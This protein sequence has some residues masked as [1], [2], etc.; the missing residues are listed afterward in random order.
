M[1]ITLEL[2]EQWLD[3][4]MANA[5]NDALTLGLG[6]GLGA[7][8]IHT[9]SS[10]PRSLNLTIA[11]TLTEEVL[12]RGQTGQPSCARCHFHIQFVNNQCFYGPSALTLTTPAWLMT[13]AADS[14][15]FITDIYLQST[16]DITLKAA[17]SA[18][19]TT[20]VRLRYTDAMLNNVAVEVL[21][22]A[23]TV[24]DHVYALLQHGQQQVTGTE[25]VHLT[26][27]TDAGAP[28]PLIATLVQPKAVLNDGGTTGELL[29]RL[30]NTSPDPVTFAP[31]PEAGSPTPTAIQLSVDLD[32]AAAW[33]LCKSDEAS[34]LV[35]SPPS[36]WAPDHPAGGSRTGQRTW[37]FRPDYSKTTQIAPNSALEFPVS[38]VRTS[39]PP[40]FTNLYVTLQEF[41]NYGT[42]T[43]VSQIEKS[44]LIY[45][46]GLN[47]GLLSKGTTGAHEGLALDGDTKGDLLLVVQSGTGS[48]A[49]FK[50]GAGVTIENNLVLSGTINGATIDRGVIT[51]TGL[52]CNG[53]A[54]VT[55]NIKALTLTVGDDALMVKDGKVTSKPLK[56]VGQITGDSL[57]IGTDVL[58]VNRNDITTSKPLS[59]AG[60]ITGGSLVIGGDALVVNNNQIKTSKTLSVTGK[61]DAAG[62]ALTGGITITGDGAGSPVLEFGYGAT[63]QAD[64]GKIGYRVFSEGLDIVGATSNIQT[65]QIHLW[66]DVYIHG[67]LWLISG[68]WCYLN[69]KSEVG[70]SGWQWATYA[71]S[72][73][74]LKKNVSRIGSPLDRLKKLNGYHFDWTEEALT[75]FAGG[76][77]TAASAGPAE[78]SRR[79]GQDDLYEAL[80][81]PQIGVIAQE[82]EAVLPEAVR[83]GENGYKSVNYHQLIALLIE[84]VREQDLAVTAQSALAARH[85]AEI[86][87]LKLAVGL[88]ESPADR[89]MLRLRRDPRPRERARTEG[90]AHAG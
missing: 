22:V 51:A 47:S 73:S 61:V 10:I 19:S 25:T 63:K 87:G 41:P 72:D 78:A 40:G 17:S 33:A 39:L 55:G 71:A 59:V 35:V 3:F 27:F 26:T 83:T 38:G 44:P 54:E 89:E 64:A 43:V 65:R 8:V 79:S 49:H 13:V 4:L 86:E 1:P 5:V 90:T 42:Q 16:A 29:L 6:D 50:G 60:Q 18:G 21:L 36:H 53:A 9:N 81:R 84:A 62:L 66:D 68:G 37:L 74:R 31:P 12:I 56:V 58:V 24:R 32:A 67:K 69:P 80:A 28:T 7:G 85:Q 34:S 48:S 30:V 11:N 77:D 75:L 45:N 70:S 88:G 82:V 46:R 14:G 57:A 15:G 76:G 2:A 52:T 23:V 20:S